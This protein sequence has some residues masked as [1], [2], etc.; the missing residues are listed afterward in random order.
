MHS[1]GT[2][3]NFPSIRT[4]EPKLRSSSKFESHESPEISYTSCH[5]GDCRDDGVAEIRM[6]AHKL[7]KGLTEVSHSLQSP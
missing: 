6:M 7:V 5:N 4:V 2:A 1:F 3:Y